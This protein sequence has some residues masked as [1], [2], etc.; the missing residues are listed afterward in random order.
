[1]QRR[2]EAADVHVKGDNDVYV[3]SMAPHCT[4]DNEAKGVDASG[5]NAADHAPDLDAKVVYVV[6]LEAAE[7]HSEGLV[8]AL[9]ASLFEYLSFLFAEEVMALFVQKLAVELHCELNPRA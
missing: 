6:A 4:T 3:Q 7:V 5:Y 8:L 9:A 2:F 1:M